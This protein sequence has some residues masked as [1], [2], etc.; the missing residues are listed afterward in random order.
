LSQTTRYA[1]V[2]AKIG[3]ERSKLLSEGKLKALTESRSL[4]ELTVQL[5]DTS[6]HEQIGK[7]TMPLTSRKL[8]RAFNENLIE[9]FI[10]I[11]K[12]SPKKAR[13][14]LGL[15]LL[16]FEIEHIKML[17]KA[18]SAKLTPENKSAKIYFSIVDYL[19]KHAVIEDA[20]KASTVNQLIHAFKGT[21]YWSALNTG[22]KNYEEN[23]STTCFDV[24]IDKFFYEKIYDSI[25]CLPKKEKQYASFYASMEND[26]FTLFTLLRGKLLGHEPNWL[27]LVIP[28]NYFNLNNA[29]VESIV[30]AVDFEA[31]FKIVLD[32]YYG[33]YFVKAQ[34]P[35]ETIA[36]AGK[37]F[38]KAVF[39]HAK[40][41]A[42]SETFNVGSPLAFMTQ[43]EAEVFN[44][45]VL[46]LSVSS[47]MKHEEL[48]NHLLL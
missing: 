24:F 45:N 28:Q 43:K 20:V 17:L 47:E 10:K 46:S 21:E 22:L 44:L 38:K 12:N 1:S 42:I 26:G 9:A 33:K 6:Y 40:S 35:E 25:G 2:L 11:I 37:A 30:S 41:S 18:T 15:Y 14:Y 7:I 3:A 39:Q 16:R 48:R 8:E 27:R 23:G 31:A 32:S 19:K 13:N 34:N 4:T 5:R 29:A 36:N